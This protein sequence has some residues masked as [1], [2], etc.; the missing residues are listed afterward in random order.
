LGVGIFLF[1]VGIVLGD[2]AEAGYGGDAPT[3]FL[4]SIFSFLFASLLLAWSVT[5]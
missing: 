3:V 2:M 5:E 4:F 1:G